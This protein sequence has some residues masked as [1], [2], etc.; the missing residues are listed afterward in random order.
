MLE[1][2]NKQTKKVSRSSEKKLNKIDFSYWIF[3]Q[4]ALLLGWVNY[5]HSGSLKIQLTEG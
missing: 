5:V 1:K 2:E 3:V 4:L